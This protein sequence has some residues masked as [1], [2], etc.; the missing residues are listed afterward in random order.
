[1]DIEHTD[2]LKT[3]GDSYVEYKMYGFN[4]VSVIGESVE[5][6]FQI[7]DN[8]PYIYENHPFLHSFCINNEFKRITFWLKAGFD[9]ADCIKEIGLELERICFNLIT[10]KNFHTFQPICVLDKIKTHYFESSFEDK[11]CLKHEL[12]CRTLLPG[13]S[14]Y[15]DIVTEKN[16]MMD[17]KKYPV[18]KQIFDILQC[19]NLVIQY[20]CLYDLLKEK[21]CIGTN[22]SQKEVVQY[23]KKKQ[24]R[25][26]ELKFFPSRRKNGKDEDN[27]TFLR[28]KIGHPW[29][30]SAEEIKKLGISEKLIQSLL[31]VIN[32]VLCEI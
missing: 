26:P 13:S 10:Y 2:I 25:Y 27:Y 6:S 5:D 30:L 29:G 19:P 20:M 28:N 4:V 22:K 24:N 1:M 31:T 17:K 3:D 12:K 11:I 23:F 21:V 16:A 9:A 18:Y 15:G 8:K 7:K 14:F 32:D